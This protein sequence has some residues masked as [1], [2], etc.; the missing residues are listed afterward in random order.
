MPFPMLWRDLEVVV[1]FR[2]RILMA[3]KDNAI[4]F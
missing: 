2:K 3:T 1:L 4:E